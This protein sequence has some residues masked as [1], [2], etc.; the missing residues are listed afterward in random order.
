VTIIVFNLQIPQGLE[1]ALIENTEGADISTVYDIG[2]IDGLN[3]LNEQQIRDKIRTLK[4]EFVNKTEKQPETNKKRS[5]NHDLLSIPYNLL[6]QHSIPDKSIADCVEALIGAYLISSGPRGA[7]LFMKWLDLKVMPKAEVENEDPNDPIWHWLPTP[8]SPL[9]LP[10]DDTCSNEENERKAKYK[11][12]QLYLGHS[13]NIFEDKLGYSFRD[14]A[15][16]VQAFTHNSYYENQ[17]TDC[18]QRLEFLGDAVLDYLIT[19]YLYEDPAGHS[20]GTLTDLRSALVNNTFFASLSVKY[21]FYK[22]L[23]MLSF[24]L[25]RV[26]NAFVYKFKVND[27]RSNDYNLFIAE[28]ESENAEDI[29]VPKALGDIFESVAGAIY[30]DSG[31]SLDAVWNVYFK[32]MKPEI[33]LLSLSTYNL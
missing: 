16:L 10:L 9:L 11:L 27:E 6:T 28:G 23:K 26:V 32:M 14:K 3:T 2:K 5:L 8:K 21:E 29:E 24:D 30:L 7:L 33:G 1:E 13:L 20:P 18:Y 31:M 15:Y 22:Y 17:V 25:F 12:N 4:N 19:R